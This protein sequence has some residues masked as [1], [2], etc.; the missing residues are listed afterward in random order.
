MIT[1]CLSTYSEGLPVTNPHGSVLSSGTII[2]VTV[3]CRLISSLIGVIVVVSEVSAIISDGNIKTA[4]DAIIARNILD[5]VL[6]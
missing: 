3:F 1:G 2:V 5:F 4:N 6:I